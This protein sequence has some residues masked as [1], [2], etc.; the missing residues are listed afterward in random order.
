MAFLLQLDKF[1]LQMVFVFI[2]FIFFSRK[3]ILS[4]NDI[5]D[6]TSFTSF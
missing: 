6:I 2:L 5:A 4:D 3:F 1:V